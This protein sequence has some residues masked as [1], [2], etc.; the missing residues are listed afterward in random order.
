MYGSFLN[1]GVSSSALEFW[2]VVILFAIILAVILLSCIIA[3]PSPVDGTY[4]GFPPDLD[5]A[6]V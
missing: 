6:G 4:Y 2:P 1:F 5:T 3:I